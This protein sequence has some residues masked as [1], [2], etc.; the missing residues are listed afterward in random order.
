MNTKASFSDAH[1]CTARHVAASN[2]RLDEGAGTRYTVHIDC[3]W[4]IR[5][6]PPFSF[7]TAAA[8]S[9]FP[10]EGV[11]GV[12]DV[13]TPPLGE[14][15]APALAGTM[16][17]FRARDR[18]IL[19]VPAVGNCTLHCVSPALA[20]ALGRPVTVLE[21]RLAFV[22]HVRANP[23]LGT[24]LRRELAVEL[25]KGTAGVTSDLCSLL[26]H[27]QRPGV[28]LPPVLVARAFEAMTGVP[29]KVWGLGHGS[30]E[31][32]ALYTPAALESWEQDV[33]AAAAE[34]DPP[35]TASVFD[36]P[37]PPPHHLELLYV[38][39]KSHAY[40]VVEQCIYFSHS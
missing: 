29:I 34:A 30:A 38:H 8:I 31:P 21:C 33:A 25:D 40:R 4:G 23:A 12:Y 9:A 19:D 7:M 36:G 2:T 14:S 17:W 16:A 18:V 35:L 10:L 11:P 27:W 3:N 28:W 13:A 32:A 24:E 20:E 37:P 26:A 15:S 39:A 6:K 22:Q 1:W 5:P